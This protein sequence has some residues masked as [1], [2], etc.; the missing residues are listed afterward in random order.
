MFTNNYSLKLF[1]DNINNDSILVK[2]EKIQEN[3]RTMELLK[4]CLE[5]C[6]EIDMDKLASITMEEIDELYEYVY[7]T[8]TGNMGSGH[9]ITKML[10]VE[11]TKENLKNLKSQPTIDDLDFF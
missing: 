3:V 10:F 9:L 2:K 6:G 11:Q 1:L 4:A 8:D 5:V 7:N